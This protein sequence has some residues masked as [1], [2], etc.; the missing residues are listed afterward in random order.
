MTLW[1][2]LKT[3]LF[4]APRP[5]RREIATT[6]D[7]RDLTRPW[8]RAL[9]RLEPQ[10]TVLQKQGG[11]YDLYHAV[12]DDWQVR[13]TFQ[14]RQLALTACEWLI[15]PGGEKRAD[16]KAAD[17]LR[18]VLLHIGW[19]QATQ[20][21]HYGVFYGFSVAECLWARDGATIT[22]DALKA[23]DRAR[24]AFLA[25]GELRLLT[26]ADP[27]KGEALPARKFW[28]FRTGADHVDEPYGLGLAHTLYWPVR[29]KK[30]GVKFWLMAAEKY[31]S[32][33]AVG[34]FP[35]GTSSADQARLLAALQ[36]IQ[37]DA[38][39]ILPE[40]VRAELLEASRSGVL[41]YERLCVYLDQAIAKIVLGQVMTSE[42]VGGQYKADVQNDVRR[43]LIKA[44]ADLI[45]ESFNRTVGRWLTDWNHP[46]AQPPRVYRQT[47]PPEDVNTRAERDQ[48]LFTLGYRPVLQDIKDVY[49]G[50][51]EDRLGDKSPVSTGSTGAP[52]AQADTPAA[53]VEPQPAADFAE[54][55]SS[56]PSFDKGGL[57]GILDR[58]GRDAD[59]VLNTLLDP[60]RQAL[61]DS[62]DLMDFRE[63]LLTLYPDLDGQAFAEL[64]GEALAVAEAAGYWEAQP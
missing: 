22:L 44:D 59:P 54:S 4:A 64:M 34:W 42:A 17:H 1:H 7:G 5:E 57:G 29:F 26:S 61:E 45:C 56:A 37:T 55:P 27:W 39:L 33:T 60:V 11:D 63:K 8:L 50:D 46:G 24:F 10:D 35:P 49:G 12:L 58:L 47:E 15:E 52:D 21:M 30:G 25:N 28:T 19:D 48:R 9:D 62:T 23:K 40:G 43:E 3:A 18:E 32:P 2:T 36:K 20:L 31:G 16:Q 6:L 13:S 14:Q 51:W 38:A 41:D 53:N